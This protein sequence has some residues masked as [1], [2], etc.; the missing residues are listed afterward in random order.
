MGII[1]SLGLYPAL[2]KRPCILIQPNIAGAEHHAVRL[3][4][5]GED[6]Q[7]LRGIGGFDF[8]DLTHN[9]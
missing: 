8:G 6:G 1:Y 5:L 2:D 4:G 3:D 7:R 9:V